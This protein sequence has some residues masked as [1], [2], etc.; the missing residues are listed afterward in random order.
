MS[1]RALAAAVIASEAKQSSFD[2][3]L[4][5]RSAPRNDVLSRLPPLL[6]QLLPIVEAFP[7][8]A[9][10]TAI[11]RLIEPLA[12]ERLRPIILPGKSLGRVVVISVIRAIAFTLHEFGRRVENRLRRHERAALL[13]GT[14]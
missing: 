4:L 2:S 6:P 9:L 1:Q 13:G 14:H 7:D 5:R 10:K 11:D 12:A 8:L 3:G